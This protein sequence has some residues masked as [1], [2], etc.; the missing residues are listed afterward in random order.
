M[1]KNLEKNPI[2]S[3]MA[4]IQSVYYA[5]FD[6]VEMCM[7]GVGGVMVSLLARHRW[8]LIEAD[9]AKASATYEDVLA[10]RHHVELL[11]HGNQQQVESILMEMT[12]RRFLVKVVDNN[13]TEWL[14]GHGASPLRFRFESENSGEADCETAY[15]L[16]FETLCPEAERRI[17]S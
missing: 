17:L 8:S 13:G 7:P 5:D 11:Y 9:E 3:A 6:N 12:Q 16:T 2:C 4:G 10:W 1:E 15:R 14:Y